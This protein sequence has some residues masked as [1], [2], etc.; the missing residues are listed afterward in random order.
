[1]TRN[2]LPLFLLPMLLASQL[3]AASKGLWGSPAARDSLP[4]AALL[5]FQDI[6]TSEPGLRTLQDRLFLEA[7][8][9]RHW[10][11]LERQRMDAILAEHAFQGSA[12]CSTSCTADLGSMLGVRT[13]LIP[14]FDRDAGIVHVSLRELDVG[15]G[16]V[17]R[18]AEAETD[19]PL[20]EASR[21]LARLLIGRLLE[22]PDV[23][24]TDS[25]AIAI[26]SDPPTT[27]W[28]DG[29]ERGSSPLTVA[30]WPGVH[31]IAVIP[32]QTLPPPPIESPPP[33]DLSATTIVVVHDDGP[34]Y[35]HRHGRRHE[36]GGR[37]QPDRY[38]AE[39]RTRNDATETQ[40]VT[41]A[42]AAVAGVALVAAAATMPDS[43]WS[44]EWRDIK[45]GT[46]DT[47]KTEFHRQ[48]NSGRGIV[49][50]LG[51]A[52]LA[53]GAVLLALAARN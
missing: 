49:G 5:S 38:E 2:L 46:A 13:L 36:R 35:G 16:E 30:V 43:V 11:L 12:S 3:H 6:P 15:S 20:S 33:A 37:F 9:V 42:V 7:F 45:V 39:P 31:R 23:P 48:E 51:I 22:D 10:R 34:R 24:V 52:I 29:I 4:T 21:T 47:V 40:A 28:V 14:E 26:T 32:G 53:I 25:G 27:I 44:D 8:K 18:L 1:M 17:L 41:G 50:V 19:Q